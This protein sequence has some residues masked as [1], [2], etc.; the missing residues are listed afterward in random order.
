MTAKRNL[1][2]V[3]ALTGG[4][5]AIAAVIAGFMITGG[6]GDARDRRLDELTR[7]RVTTVLNLAQCAFDEAGAA[8][9]QLVDVEGIRVQNPDGGWPTC[10]LGESSEQIAGLADPNVSAPGAVTYEMSSTSHIR[11]CANF[12]RPSPPSGKVE[13]F[14]SL[15][16]SEFEKPHPA[17]AHCFD[18]E[19]VK[20]SGT[21]PECGFRISH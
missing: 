12:R 21:A 5:I 19:L 1:G 4:G 3:L 6:P 16:Y 11:I 18:I 17:G 20:G 7:G 9:A 14:E 15:G 13:C 2:P 8:P 10:A